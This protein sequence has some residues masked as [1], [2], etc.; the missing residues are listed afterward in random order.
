MRDLYY[1]YILNVYIRMYKALCNHTY[2]HLI[3][4]IEGVHPTGPKLV[5]LFTPGTR[6]VRGPDWRYM[7]GDQ[8]IM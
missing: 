8:V 1:N 4:F 6:V 7:Y 2:V 5:H 3:E